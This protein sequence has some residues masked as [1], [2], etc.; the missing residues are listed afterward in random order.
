MFNSKFSN[1]VGIN[2]ERNSTA[3]DVALLLTSAAV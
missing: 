1:P 3:F 2:I